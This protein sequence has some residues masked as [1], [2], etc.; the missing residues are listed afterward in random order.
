MQLR[1]A[2]ALGMMEQHHRGIGDIHPHLHD[3]RRHQRRHPAG[4]ELLHHGL[5]LV[6]P[7]LAL[8]QPHHMRCQSLSPFAMRLDGALGSTAFALLNQRIDKIRLPTLLQLPP[9]KRRDIILLGCHSHRGDHPSSAR[10]F[11][12]ENR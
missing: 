7:H 5:L 8:P 1:Q 10:R 9:H 11:F 4:P 3:G 2:K 6:G 12:I